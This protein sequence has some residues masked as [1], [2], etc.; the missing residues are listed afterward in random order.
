MAGIYQK[1]KWDWLFQKSEVISA[2]KPL[3]GRIIGA[4]ALGFS[5][6]RSHKSSVIR[7]LC[8]ALSIGENDV[9]KQNDAFVPGIH[10]KMFE[11][12]YYYLK[13][14]HGQEMPWSEGENVKM[15]ISI[16]VL[17]SLSLSGHFEQAFWALRA[18][19]LSYQADGPCLS[20]FS[21]KSSDAGG[22]DQ[23]NLFRLQ[24]LWSPPSGHKNT[25]SWC[26]RW[27]PVDGNLVWSIWSVNISR[28]KYFWLFLMPA[29][30]RGI[31]HAQPG[32]IWFSFS[33]QY[34]HPAD[35]SRCT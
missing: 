34:Y 16:A 6:P 12:H 31:S 23:N 13:K 19:S 15:I 29:F 1:S 24:N 20:T 14:N 5:I 33:P 32:I 28:D 17:E 2:H 10:F 8:F 3:P 26:M 18:R 22:L 4:S 35:N 21:R 25:G 7:S 27:C 11:S 9:P 30:K